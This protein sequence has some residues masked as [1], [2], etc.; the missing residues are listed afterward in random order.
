MLIPLT[1]VIKKIQSNIFAPTPMVLDYIPLE[2]SHSLIHPEASSQ[3]CNLF[4]FLLPSTSFQQGSTAHIEVNYIKRRVHFD[5]KVKCTLPLGN[6]VWV[7]NFYEYTHI[8]G[9]KTVNPKGTFRQGPLDHD[10]VWNFCWCVY[11]G[12]STKKALMTR[13]Y[14]RLMAADHSPTMNTASFVRLKGKNKIKNEK[15]CRMQ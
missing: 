2:C 4:F 3:R 13:I 10:M 8:S 12:C 5:V 7:C 1:S 6:I 15:R 11:V 9:M 14:S